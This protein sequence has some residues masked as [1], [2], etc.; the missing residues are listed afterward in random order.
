MSQS[1]ALK[2]LLERYAHGD[3]VLFP[4]SVEHS[5]GLPMVYWSTECD[6]TTGPVWCNNLGDVSYAVLHS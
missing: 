2:A 5:C 1:P 3:R 6:P 4:Y